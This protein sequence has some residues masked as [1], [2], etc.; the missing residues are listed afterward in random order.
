MASL[1]SSSS[2]SR[3]SPLQA[4]TG[5]ACG[6]VRTTRAEAS[7]SGADRSRSRPLRFSGQQPPVWGGCVMAAAPAD[8]GRVTWACPWPM[9]GRWML[10]ASCQRP[11]SY[12]SRKSRAACH[13]RW[14]R[15]GGHDPL[16]SVPKSPVIQH[17]SNVHRARILSFHPVP[18]PVRPPL[19][20]TQDIPSMPIS[21]RRWG[22]A[23]L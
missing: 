6:A 21:P 9:D 12:G 1:G 11:H 15:L 10:R 18:L 3:R 7:P 2:E 14:P 17:V 4:D 23:G 20:K 5:S 13:V 22:E 8:G 19:L 16:P